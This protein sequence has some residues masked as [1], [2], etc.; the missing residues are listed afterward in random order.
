MVNVNGKCCDHPDGCSKHPHFG[1]PGSPAN[2]CATH[3]E[4]GMV[5]LDRNPHA[6]SSPSSGLCTS[7]HHERRPAM[8]YTAVTVVVRGAAVVP[9]RCAQF[10]HLRRQA[11]DLLPSSRVA[12]ACRRHHQGRSPLIIPPT[13]S[14][15]PAQPVGSARGQGRMLQSQ[16][17]CPTGSRQQAAIAALTRNPVGWFKLFSLRMNRPARQP[18]LPLHLVKPPTVRLSPAGLCVAR[19]PYQPPW[20]SPV[21][22]SGRE[23]LQPSSRPQLLL[24]LL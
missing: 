18:E 3:K 20:L 12:S 7:S 17:Q 2:R 22:T 9:E 14:P 10:L 16:R 6:R 1:Q 21:A 4:P 13:A 19:L 15:L 24:R 5:R 11:A 8:L 23:F